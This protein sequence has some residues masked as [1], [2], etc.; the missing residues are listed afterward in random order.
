MSAAASTV[1]RIKKDLSSCQISSI[2]LNWKL[3]CLTL[4]S[5]ASRITNIALSSLSLS[6]LGPASSTKVGGHVCGPFKKKNASLPAVYPVN[7]IIITFSIN[8]IYMV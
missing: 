3:L 4:L 6:C 8:S 7:Y 2:Y 1:E 5:F